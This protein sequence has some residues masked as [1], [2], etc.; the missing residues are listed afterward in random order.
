[1]LFWDIVTALL[2]SKE[3][4]EHHNFQVDSSIS[5]IDI[6]AKGNKKPTVDKQVESGMSLFPLH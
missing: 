1:M 3:S 4:F 5:P 2:A 6:I